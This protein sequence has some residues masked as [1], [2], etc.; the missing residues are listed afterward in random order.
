M[1]LGS[2]TVFFEFRGS[3]GLV[4]SSYAC[5]A[6]LIFLDKKKRVG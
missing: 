6:V 2:R 1:V 4:F 5:L 3:C